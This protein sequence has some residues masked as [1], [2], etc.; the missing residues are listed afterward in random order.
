MKLTD[1]LQVVT[2]RRS[3]DKS[4]I[5]TSR[6]RN[7]LRCAIL[8]QKLEI[9]ICIFTLKINL[10]FRQKY[11][12]VLKS[13]LTTCELRNRNLLKPARNKARAESDYPVSPNPSLD[14]A[15]RFILFTPNRI[16]RYSLSFFPRLIG[17][18]SKLLFAN[19]AFIIINVCACLG[20]CGRPVAT[21]S[22]LCKEQEKRQ[23]PRR[24]SEY[25]KIAQAESK[26]RNTLLDF[27]VGRCS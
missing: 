27:A 13:A 23:D 16:S 3:L 12:R 20:G 10:L 25:S 17:T 21:Y 24:M 14:H 6:P 2:G 19:A 15:I 4:L 18:S 8:V 5:W 26:S 22:I 7:S 9:R 11:W 1:Q